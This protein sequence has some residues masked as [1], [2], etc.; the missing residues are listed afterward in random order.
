VLAATHRPDEAVSTSEMSVNFYPTTR[1]NNPEDNHLRTRRHE[2]LKSHS[3][4]FN[5]HHTLIPRD[6]FNV[7][8]A[9]V[10][11]VVVVIVAVVVV[12]VVV[13]VVV[14]V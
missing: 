7:V 4:D 1:C 11:V 14:V 5:P 8:A 12:V 9:T 3:D 6:H 13:A 10:V 2:N